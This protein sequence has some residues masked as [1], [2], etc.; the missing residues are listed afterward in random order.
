MA[1]DGSAVARQGCS[2]GPRSTPSGPVPVMSGITPCSYGPSG[3]L[4]PRAGRSTQRPEG[5]AY[6]R[7]GRA[8]LGGQDPSGQVG[9][10]LLATTSFAGLRKDGTAR[11]SA[12]S[13]VQ[14]STVDARR[15][16]VQWP[17]A[18]APKRRYWPSFRTALT[19]C[20]AQAFSD[21]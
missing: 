16:L 1:E 11:R 15:N 3:K 21:S 20:A 10:T 14:Q 8:P 7:Q 18:L 9:R 19:R 2:A 17:R 13:A 5:F 4:S 6:A 12:A